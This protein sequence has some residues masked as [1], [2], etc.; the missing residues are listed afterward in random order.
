ME[1]AVGLVLFTIMSATVASAITTM[2]ANKTT[3]QVYSYN[4]VIM[5]NMLDQ[6]RLDFQYAKDV[7]I[8]WQTR[9]YEQIMLKTSIPNSSGGSTPERIVIYSVYDWGATKYLTRWEYTENWRYTSVNAFGAYNPSLSAMAQRPLS[10]GPSNM[11][12]FRVRCG[13][14][15]TSNYNTAAKNGYC[16]NGYNTNGEAKL[17]NNWWGAYDPTNAISRLQINTIVVYPLVNNRTNRYTDTVSQKYRRIP[18]Y[19]HASESYAILADT[20]YG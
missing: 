10:I 3:D 6:M 8:P 19:T 9:S 12:Q 17:G 13:R 11:V 1:M 14:F 5:N 16:F 15:S 20:P 7:F 4:Q 18:Y 2:L